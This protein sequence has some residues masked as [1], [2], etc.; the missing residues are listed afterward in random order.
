MTLLAQI[1]DLHIDNVD[2]D[3][4]TQIDSRANALAVLDAVQQQKIKRLVLNGD[5]AE[6]ENGIDWFLEQIRARKFQYNLILGNHDLPQIYRD[7]N[8]FGGPQTYHA[9]L[10]EGFLILF[11]D[12]GRNSIDQ[13]QLAW[14][15]EQLFQTDQEVLIFVHHPV[16]DCGNSIMDRKYPLKNR[17]EV[18]KILTKTNRKI[19]LFCG[20]YHREE[21]VQAQNIT[22]HLTPSTYYQIKKYAAGIEL[23][24]EAVG[25][26]V[27]SLK[28]GK[29]ETTVKYLEPHKPTGA[30][31]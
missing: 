16:L 12:S 22:Q 29:Y 23:E 28:A 27:L 19:A 17:A 7:K 18:L 6:T 5:I 1:T 21:I 20:H 31:S 14:I 2:P 3:L 15:E 9:E 4:I 25:Y 24:S 26:R 8:I 10:L 13:E 11:L 30:L